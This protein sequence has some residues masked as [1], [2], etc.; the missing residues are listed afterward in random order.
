MVRILCIGN[1]FYYPDDFGIEVYFGLQKRDLEDIELIEGGVGGMSLLPYFED[2]TPLIIVDF[3]TMKKKI[4]TKED[5]DAIKLDGFDH[6][7]AFL[8]LLKSVE[9]DFMVYTCNELYDKSHIDSFVDE[10]LALARS[11]Q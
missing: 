5:I 3:S 4:M 7:N 1:R 6:A 11:L 10:V 2:D 8:Y 9:K